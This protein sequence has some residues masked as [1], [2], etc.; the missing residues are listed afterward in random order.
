MD[1]RILKEGPKIINFGIE[2][3]HDDQKAQKVPSVQ[4]D[5]KPSKMS[6]TFMDKLRKLQQ[7]R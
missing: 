7:G 3:F 2:A 1:F 4:V 5:W 6:S